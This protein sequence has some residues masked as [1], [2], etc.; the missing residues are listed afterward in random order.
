MK[1]SI[2]MP[3]Y[4]RGYLLEKVLSHLTSQDYEDVEY[5][6]VDDG[7]IDNTSEVVK[8]FKK[9]KYIYQENGG[10]ASARNTGIKNAEGDVILFIDSDVFVPSNIASIHAKYHKKYDKCIVQGQLVRIIN[11][12]DAFK[13]KFTLYDY[14]RSFFD[15]A[16]VSVKKKYLIEAGLFDDKSFKKGWEDL[17]LGLRLIKNGL[18][19]KRIKEGYVWHYEGN[20]TREAILD[21]FM[22]RKREGKAS[23]DFYR[24]HPN[25]ETKMMTMISPLFLWLSDKI[26]NTQFYKSEKFYDKIKR[27]IEKNKKSQAIAKVRLAGYG[28][29]F[30]GV[31]ERIEEDGY[32]LL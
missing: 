22:D 4:N 11:I 26:Y 29:Y 5:V 15:T 21:F 3:V 25:F 16:N 6:I 19:V 7:S 23:L 2:V 14:S 18:R 10:C 12:D 1:I 24:K 13:V 28:F 9:V 17:D 27:M 30:E 32:I 31:K 8:K 20:Y